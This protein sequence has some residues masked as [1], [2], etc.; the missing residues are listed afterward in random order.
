M[1]HAGSALLHVEAPFL[2]DSTLLHVGETSWDEFALAV[3]PDMA[4]NFQDFVAN[5]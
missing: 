2:L 3:S 5:L 4:E 1:S